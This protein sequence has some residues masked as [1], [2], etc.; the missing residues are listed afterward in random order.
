MV[1]N[2]FRAPYIDTELKIFYD[3]FE[4]EYFEYKLS[5]GFFMKIMNIFR[6][7]YISII[8]V[9]KVDVVYSIFAGFHSFFPILIGKILKKKTIITVAGFDTVSIPSIKF[10]V[11]YKNNL[12][13]Y[14]VRKQF[15][16]A[17]Y[18]L[19]VDESL[20][21]SVNYYA[22]PNGV[23]Y[24]NGVKNF[25]QT[26][27]KI[28]TIPFGYDNQR[29][30]RKL[31]LKSE[32]DVITIGWVT[33]A[34]VFHRKG[35]DLVLEA[36]KNLPN[37]SFLIVGM[38]KEIQDTF[39]NSISENITIKEFVDHDQMIN[40]LSASKV[41]LQLSLS[42]GLPNTLC[43]AMLCEC[44]PIGSDVNGIPKAIGNTGYVLKV[45]NVDI[46]KSYIEEALKMDANQGALARERIMSMF[47][48]SKRIEG[49]KTIIN[50]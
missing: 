24:P 23:G 11:F 13:Q 12:L 50:S 3:N 20:E 1:C 22:D 25:V 28:I 35:F 30:K 40:L 38:S 10:G 31:N 49:L 26:H 46:L 21:M 7:L 45:K 19:P 8:V 48:L 41:Y 5:K 42:E 27:A 15:L 44:I 47:P 36:A 37:V 16:W 17:D 34:Q 39:Y 18:I 14:C 33:T 29:F 6:C 32:Y 4:I 2:A 9:P 43:E